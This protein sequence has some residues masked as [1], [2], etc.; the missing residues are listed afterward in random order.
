MAGSF[1]V[2][3]DIAQKSGYLN[4]L[5]SVTFTRFIFA[6]LFTACLAR[7]ISALDF[8]DRLTEF[9]FISERFFK[10][11]SILRCSQY[12]QYTISNCL[13]AGYIPGAYLQI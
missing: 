3:Q 9:Q 11:D 4:K 1:L 10:P 7:G 6:F 2:L 12:L 5:K 13:Y 8:G